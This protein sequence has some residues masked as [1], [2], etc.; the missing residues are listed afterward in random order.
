MFV[1]FSFLVGLWFCPVNKTSTSCVGSAN[2]TPR[3]E[4]APQHTSHSGI[5]ISLSPPQAKCNAPSFLPI[6]PIFPS[7]QWGV[8]AVP[9]LQFPR[10]GCPLTRYQKQHMVMSQRTAT[11]GTNYPHLPQFWQHWDAADQSHHKPYSV[12]RHLQLQKV[13]IRISYATSDPSP[14]NLTPWDR[15]SRGW[16]SVCLVRSYSSFLSLAS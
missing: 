15:F 5:P 16:N 11:S 8:S 3:M 13:T 4:G 2:L 6:L 9:V 10:Q 14:E 12:A 7:F 1:T